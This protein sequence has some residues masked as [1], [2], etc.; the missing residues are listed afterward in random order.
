ME[1][2][3]WVVFDVSQGEFDSGELLALWE[4]SARA[5]AR[6]TAVEILAVWD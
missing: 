4:R 3:A 1:N 2:G 5:I 6:G